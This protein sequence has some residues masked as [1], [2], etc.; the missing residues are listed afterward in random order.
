MTFPVAMTAAMAVVSLS[1]AAA[2]AQHRA[3]PGPRPIPGGMFE[4]SGVAAV[5]SMSGA[6]F[7]DDGENRDVFWIRFNEQEVAEPAR[8]VAL[9]ATVPDME[10][11]TTDGAT[12][13]AVGSQSK[14]GKNAEGLV[15]FR[16]DPAAGRISSV[17]SVRG[18]RAVLTTA[19]PELSRLTRGRGNDLNV[20][21]LTWD[22]ARRRL[23]LGLR[24][25]Q[26]GGDALLIAMRLRSADGP[27]SADNLAI[28]P[29]I[30]RVNLG[31]LSVRGL[32]SDAATGRILLIGGAATDD[33]RTQFRL[34]EWD[35][36]SNAPRALHPL[37][38]AQKPEGV[39][40]IALGGRQRTLLVFDG[41]SYQ[42]LD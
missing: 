8:R 4:A 32:A 19:V 34:F 10:D 22:Q 15:R 3:V 20:E 39:T 28:D 12:F 33:P 35:G 13:Y 41:G 30:I 37:S 2:D 27:L 23:L 38:S 21:G 16:F 25:P 36:T 11:I 40:R 42:L 5:P 1:L 31:G 14:G 18:L 7:V 6:L 24:A 26:Q 29:Q 9:G 17:E